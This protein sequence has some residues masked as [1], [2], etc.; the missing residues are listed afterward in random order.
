MIQ[1]PFPP[2]GEGMSVPQEQPQVIVRRMPWC[3]TSVCL[4]VFQHLEY[5][6]KLQI[7]LVFLV[8][9]SEPLLR[10]EQIFLNFKTGVHSG[11]RDVTQQPSNNS[12]FRYVSIQSRCNVI[13]NGGDDF[14]Q[15]KYTPLAQGWFKALVRC[16]SPR[17][18]LAWV[19]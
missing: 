19:G 9:T 14:K 4:S 2:K 7:D 8:I 18:G 3:F 6:L 11:L 5:C 17:W 12:T 1:T 16:S 10:V 15:I 13:L